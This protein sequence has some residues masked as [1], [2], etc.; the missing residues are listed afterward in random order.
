ML[1]FWL[2]FPLR[3]IFHVFSQ[4]DPTAYIHFPCYTANIVP[5]EKTLVSLG[6]FTFEKAPKHKTTYGALVNPLLGPG[7][8]EIAT[9]DSIGLGS[10]LGWPRLRDMKGKQFTCLT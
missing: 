4:N 5:V 8:A 6:L 10:G 7:R 2:S 9:P 3:T 1:R